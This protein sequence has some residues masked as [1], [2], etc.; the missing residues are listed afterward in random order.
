MHP[1]P[2]HQF[3]DPGV[4]PDLSFE[5]VTLPQWLDRTATRYPE[6]PALIFRNRTL[7]YQE[8]KNQVDRLASALA[9][10]GV[11]QG[12]RVAM[13]FP[14]LP[15]MVI[16]YYAVQVL[17]AVA[18]PTNP[19]YTPREIEYQWNDA[20]CAVAIL[21]DFI[22]A[23]K[24]AGIRHRLS[25]RHYV[26]GSIPEYLK[27]PLSLL[28]PL[29]LKRAKPPLMA[30]F[31][32]SPTVHRFR[33]LVRASPPSPPGVTIGMSDLSTL[34][35]TGGTTGVSKGAM[36]TQRNLSCN[37]QQ[38]RAWF[39]NAQDGKETILGALPFFHSFGLTV[40]MNLSVRLA[41]TLVLIPNPRDIP[42]IIQSIV[43]H[44]I[45]LMAAVPA[46]FQ[47]INQYP[48]I[49]AA[50]LSSVRMCN[51]GSAPLSVDVLRR[52]E[53]LTG[54]RISEGFGL[55]E[56]SPV[57]HCNPLFSTRKVGSIGVP[58]PAT[59]ARIVDPEDGATTLPPGT[60]G[61]LLL[62]GPQVMAGYWKKPEE[63]AKV[64]RDGWLYTGDLCRMD[65]DG[66]HFIE[67]R[68]KDMIISSGFNVYPDEI[69]R[70][71][72]AHPAVLEAAS[73]GIPDPKRGESIKAFV[74]LRPG[75]QASPDDLLAHCREQLAAYKVPRELEFRDSLPRSSVLKILR[76]ELR[77]EELAKRAG[78]ATGPTSGPG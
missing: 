78:S 7:T 25:V 64:L 33:D 62:A 24:V 66:F 9:G 16:S 11:H 59:D 36:L 6:R 26:V 53:Q 17:G 43:K 12:D 76:R 48:G 58:L 47:A 5:D 37:M 39:A 46:T 20:E 15:H 22:F 52:F 2:W 51:S 73:I 45:T 40:A 29:K 34:L 75:M 23:A 70:V 55:T 63:T 21:P 44:R 28:A 3:Y 35:Y 41:A 4:P 69:D 57:T 67:G 60:V 68:K 19:L 13:Q 71:L 49:A 10:L 14:N 18:V 54:G 8:L 50:D 42:A 31:E 74:V 32:T 38:M 72:M 61:E 1:R 30:D 27:F 65:E 56:T 77:A